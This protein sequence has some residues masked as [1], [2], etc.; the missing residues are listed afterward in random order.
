MGFRGLKWQMSKSPLMMWGLSSGL[1]PDYAPRVLSGTFGGFWRPK[2]QSPH[3]GEGCFT[4][5]QDCITI[6]SNTDETTSALSLND[7][8]IE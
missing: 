1:Q 5:T 6:H 4:L 8:N 7:R 3:G 2:F